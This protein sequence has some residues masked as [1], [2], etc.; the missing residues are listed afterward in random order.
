MLVVEL[1]RFRKLVRIHTCGLGVETVE[2]K[3]LSFTVWDVGGKDK[4][5]SLWH[6]FY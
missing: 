1:C 5:C 4:V 3:N 2:N 6:H